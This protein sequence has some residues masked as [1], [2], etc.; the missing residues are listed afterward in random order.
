M[1]KLSASELSESSRLH[2]AIRPENNLFLSPEI[3][4]VC[5]IICWGGVCMKSS[6]GRGPIPADNSDIALRRRLNFMLYSTR[7][8]SPV[9]LVWGTQFRNKVAGTSYTVTGD[10][11]I[12]Q[13]DNG[14]EFRTWDAYHIKS[15]VYDVIRW[16]LF[17]RPHFRW[18]RKSSI[19]AAYC[20]R[21][22][23]TVCLLITF[24]SLAK[25]AELIQMPLRG[26]WL[27]WV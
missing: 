8:P 19:D 22:S 18:H 7:K 4:Q 3:S 21:R 26:A 10:S 11:S 12:D 2:C 17:G 5:Q 20:D 24:V 25:T 23:S 15:S 27:T 14:F 9:A 16:V 13:P 1:V 6:R